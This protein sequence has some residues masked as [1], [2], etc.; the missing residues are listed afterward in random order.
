M[1]VARL[2]KDKEDLAFLLA[3]LGLLP[4][5]KP[6]VLTP[7]ERRRM[8]REELERVRKSIKK[9]QWEQEIAF[10]TRNFK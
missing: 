8:E 4:E 3:M 10:L 6:D 1:N 5:K 7:K 9:T 2:A